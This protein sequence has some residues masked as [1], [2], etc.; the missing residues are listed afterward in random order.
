MPALVDVY[1]PSPTAF[2]NFCGKL[3]DPAY[4]KGNGFNYVF[5]KAPGDAHWMPLD[6]YRFDYSRGFRG[7][8]RVLRDADADAEAGGGL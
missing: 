1:F 4:D 5:H 8:E 2:N 3:A 7:K 6:Y